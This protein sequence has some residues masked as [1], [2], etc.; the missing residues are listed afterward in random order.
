M[1]TPVQ[2][3]GTTA[4]DAVDQD[5]LAEEL[6]N[7][8]DAGDLE[9]VS[10]AAPPRLARR[11]DRD[12]DDDREERHSLPYVEDPRDA[13]V[14]SF[15]KARKEQGRELTTDAE[16]DE[17]EEAGEA[18]DDGAD[19]EVQIVAGPGARE[20]AETKREPRRLTDLND[21]DIV[22][23]KV[24]GADVEMTYGE[25]RRNAQMYAASDNRLKTANQLL[26]EMR[27]IADSIKN[28]PA[29][30]RTDARPGGETVDQTARTAPPGQTKAELAQR[31]TKAAE[32]LQTDSPEK[33]AEALAEVLAE[34]QG[35][36]TNAAEVARAVIDEDRLNTTLRHEVNLALN[37]VA[38]SFDDV[39]KDKRL[40]DAAYADVL[41]SVTKGLREIGVE[42][43]DFAALAQDCQRSGEIYPLKLMEQYVRIRSEHP[44]WAQKLKPIGTLMTEAAGAAR[45]WYTGDRNV[46]V[47]G[48]PVTARAQQSGRTEVRQA[49]GNQPPSRVVRTA[50]RSGR[51]DGLTT[52][53]RSGSIRITSGGP[54]APKAKN[55]TATVAEMAAQRN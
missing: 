43:S 42:P 54:P 55:T 2:R 18:A 17:A 16:D 40:G 5:A 38:T 8:G 41:D 20:V 24:D 50:E 37:E 14:A 21:D 51:K 15:A 48:K 36:Q 12:D 45:E 1:K 19:P 34:I 10:P 53:P 39:I 29:A 25:M 35:G 9:D 32:L 33:G 28:P 22:T 3:K 30:A 26:D 27:S 47:D 6:A 11:E 46:R 7:A 44:T 4:S 13:L 49:G 52:Q 31:L 23:V